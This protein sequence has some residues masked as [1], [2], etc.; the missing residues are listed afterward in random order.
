MNHFLT[1]T[2]MRVPDL[3]ASAEHLVAILGMHEAWRDQ[4]SAG[5]ALPNQPVCLELVTGAAAIESMTL[6]TDAANVAEI[7]ARAAAHGAHVLRGADDGLALL[8][9]HGVVVDVVAGAPSVRNEAT[10]DDGPV[11]GSIDHLSFTTRDL[12]ASVRFFCDVLGFRLSDRV[13]EARYWLRCNRNHHTVALFEGGDGLQH[14]A[15]EASGVAELKRLGDALAV[16][17]ENFL[18]GIGRHGLGENVFSYHLDPAG[19]ILELCSDMAQI[20]DEEAWHVG[21]WDEHSPTSAIR[22]GQLPPPEFRQ[23]TIPTASGL[24]RA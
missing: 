4:T 14:Y 18:W 19:A 23:T 8:A 7:R 16:R 13:G 10:R 24:A 12:Q 9:P 6:A 17:G 20:P 1:R 21:V 22:W 15:F 5:L 2:R 11:V 3:D